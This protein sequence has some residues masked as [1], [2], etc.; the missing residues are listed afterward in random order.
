MK[1]DNE[2]RLVPSRANVLICFAV[3]EEARPFQQR[4]ARMSQTRADG[5]GDRVDK[6]DDP[7]RVRVLLTE[8]GRR[9]AERSV[10]AALA[11]VRPSLVLSCGFAGGL[12][13]ELATG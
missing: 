3:K 13:P 5:R 8:M 9:K 2:A 11:E 12:R 10:L 4:L 1:A 7:G 6:N